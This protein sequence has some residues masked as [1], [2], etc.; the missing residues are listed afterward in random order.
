MDTY[1]LNLEHMNEEHK[2]R[3]A[4]AAKEDKDAKAE[5]PAEAADA[6]KAPAKPKRV[7]KPRAKKA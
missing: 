5:A 6:E 2:L 4:K 3:A 7:C 1:R